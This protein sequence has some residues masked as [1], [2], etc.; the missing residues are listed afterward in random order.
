MKKILVFFVTLTIL[1]LVSSSDLISQPPSGCPPG[2]TNSILT[3]FTIN[4]CDFEVQICWRCK[5]TSSPLVYSITSITQLTFCTPTV[6]LLEALDSIY[7]TLQNP[8]WLYT[9]C[10][11][12]IPPC[13]TDTYEFSEV[14]YNYFK[15][16]QPS[17]TPLPPVRNFV[18][19]YSTW[20]QKDYSACMLSPGN[21]QLTVINDWYQVG[22]P[23]CDTDEPNNPD[24]GKDSDCWLMKPDCD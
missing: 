19:D 22:V 6:D 15:K 9:F 4:G 24:P 7:V 1:L 18:C 10:G 3:T 21:M 17:G 5:V 12:D 14:R 2:T 20:C 23:T 8:T 11:D 16:Y 13:S